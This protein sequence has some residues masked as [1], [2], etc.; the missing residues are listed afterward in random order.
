SQVQDHRVGVAAG[1]EG[2]GLG[3]GRG[4]LHV[5]PAGAQVDVHGVQDRGFVVD[6][7]HLAHGRSVVVR[8]TAAP[9]L[10]LPGGCGSKRN[11][12]PGAVMKYRGRAGSRSTLRR[13]PAI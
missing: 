9:V 2:E 10:V 4:E 5:I 3:A 11:P 12:R 6:D 1:G 13:M 8:S 7:E